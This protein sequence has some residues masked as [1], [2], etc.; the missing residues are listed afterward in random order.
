MKHTRRLIIIPE[1]ELG[2]EA[3]KSATSVDASG[4]SGRAVANV[5]PEA[6][7][8]VEKPER[9]ARFRQYQREQ[10]GDVYLGRTDLSSSGT[11]VAEPVKKFKD[12]ELK[13]SDRRYYEYSTNTANLDSLSAHGDGDI[14]PVL[15][16]TPEDDAKI[17]LLITDSGATGTSRFSFNIAE[18]QRTVYSESSGEFSVKTLP[19]DAQF[20]GS[21]TVFHKA[22]DVLIS[23]DGV[24]RR[25]VSQYDESPSITV[26][27]VSGSDLERRQYYYCRPKLLPL[28]DGRLMS[29]YIQSNMP[30]QH[31]SLSGLEDTAV[32]GQDPVVLDNSVMIQY[33]SDETGK[34]GQA[35]E[36]DPTNTLFYQSSDP[37]TK[38]EPE[39]AA[40][41][42]DAIQFEDTGE[43]V[44]VAGT[45]TVG[46]LQFNLFDNGDYVPTSTSDPQPVGDVNISDLAAG[47]FAQERNLVVLSS[48]DGGQTWK[49]RSLL[50]LRTSGNGIV[51]GALRSD[52]PGLDED[53]I[54][55][56]LGGACEVLDT[57]RIVVTLCTSENIYLLSSDDRGKS[58][59]ASKIKQIS[60][61]PEVV[62]VAGYQATPP[63]EG[64]AIDG[65]IYIPKRYD[66][67]VNGVV[68]GSELDNLDPGYYIVTADEQ[69][70]G[71]QA[72]PI[73][74][75]ANSIF[76]L[77]NPHPGTGTATV[78][79]LRSPSEGATAWASGISVAGSIQE[80]R[81]LIFDT[82]AGAWLEWDARGDW[83]GLLDEVPL[84]YRDSPESN[85]GAVL[86]WVPAS[87]PFGTFDRS[88][89]GSSAGMILKVI[90]GEE[91]SG[92]FLERIYDEQNI[93]TLGQGAF[94]W[95][96]IDGPLLKDRVKARDTLMSAGMTKDSSGAIFCSVSYTDFNSLQSAPEYI[97][98][99]LMKQ[100]LNKDYYVDE[101]NSKLVDDVFTY[102]SDILNP[103]VMHT[104]RR[105]DVF[106]TKDGESST[107]SKCWS[108][109]SAGKA[110][111]EVS[112]PPN[113][114]D[115]YLAAIENSP[116][117]LQDEVFGPACLESSVSIRPDGFPQVYAASHNWMPPEFVG[118]HNDLYLDTNEVP[119]PSPL[120]SEKKVIRNPGVMNV[121]ASQSASQ[122]SS[123][124]DG[125]FFST[126]TVSQ[127]NMSTSQFTV[128]G[129]S[130]DENYEIF[131]NEISLGRMGTEFGERVESLDPRRSSGALPVHGTSSYYVPQ[132]FVHPGA[133]EFY[134][135]SGIKYTTGFMWGLN[136][137]VFMVEDPANQGQGTEGTI[138][139]SPWDDETATLPVGHTVHNVYGDVI[140]GISGNLFF[141]QRFGFDFQAGTKFYNPIVQEI[142]EYNGGDRSNN[143]SYIKTATG[144]LDFVYSYTDNK[145][146][147][148]TGAQWDPVTTNG[149]TKKIKALRNINASLPESGLSKYFV[150]LTGGVTGIDCVQWRG[151]T[152]VLACHT[153]QYNDR[154]YSHSD[155]G[156][157]R[158]RSLKSGG[159]V[160]N[161][162]NSSVV[163][164]KSS[165]WQPIR[166]N[167]GRI[168]NSWDIGM[169]SSWADSLSV[170]GGTPFRDLAV[171]DT[172]EG[173]DYQY[174]YYYGMAGDGLNARNR[175]MRMMT[176]RWYQCTF[177]GQRDP[178]RAGWNV[179]SSSEP[180][181]ATPDSQ[182]YLIDSSMPSNI[183]TSGTGIAPLSDVAAEG[184]GCV[185]WRGGNGGSVVYLGAAENTV[186]NNNTMFLPFSEGRQCSP[187]ADG[188]K[189]T[190]NGS[191]LTGGFRVIFSPFSQESFT[192]NT[193]K[194]FFSLLLNN[195]Q[196]LP[197]TDVDD[198][199]QPPTAKMAGIII[200]LGYDTTL[201]KLTMQAYDGGRLF[202]GPPSN[203]VE[204][205]K[206]VQFDLPAAEGSVDWFEIVA[207]IEESFT[208]TSADGSALVNPYPRPTC[209]HA[210]ARKWSRDDD[211]DWLKSYDVMVN[212]TNIDPHNI[213][214]NSP[215]DGPKGS[216]TSVLFNQ[217]HFVVGNMG[218]GIGGTH[219]NTDE[220]GVVIKSASLHRPGT[221]I[222]GGFDAALNIPSQTGSPLAPNQLGGGIY[223]I[224]V[225]GTD[226][227]IPDMDIVATANDGSGKYLQGDIYTE[228]GPI[229]PRLALVDSSSSD[230]YYG[231]PMFWAG[232]G[233]LQLSENDAGII[234][235][236]KTQQ[237]LSI[238]SWIYRGIKC[239]WRGSAQEAATFAVESN[240]LF[241]AGNMLEGP[242]TKTWKTAKGDTA[243]NVIEQRHQN[244]S[245]PST[246]LMRSAKEKAYVVENM[247]II[248]DSWGEGG[249]AASGDYTNDVY[250]KIGTR[251]Q[252]SPNGIAMFGKN[253]P[254]F[255]ISFYN[256]D[257]DPD[258]VFTRTFG[259]PGDGRVNSI[260]SSWVNNE[261]DRYI[262]LWAW[263]SETWTPQG[264]SSEQQ[265][266]VT[267]G[268]LRYPYF[269]DFTFSYQKRSTT[270][271]HITNLY[272]KDSAA[273]K[274]TPWMPHQFKSDKN[275][276]SYYMQVISEDLAGKSNEACRFIFKIVDNT[277]DTLI[278]D[279]NPLRYLAQYS[280]PVGGTG[281]TVNPPGGEY[282]S[283]KVVSI[284]S[285]RM[286]SEIVYSVI[287]DESKRSGDDGFIFPQTPTL[288]ATGFRYAKITVK[289]CSR[290]GEE[291]SQKLG[292]LIMGRMLDLSGPD[293]EW[294]WSRSEESGVSLRTARGGQRFARKRHSP[295]RKFSVSHHPLR[296]AEEV[297]T[298]DNQD[299]NYFES[300]R[301]GFGSQFG[302]GY[303]QEP[304]T[305]EE[306]V[307]LLRSL[308]P[309]M[310]QA[311]LVWEGD[312]AL[313]SKQPG[314][315]TLSRTGVPCDPT[316]LCLVR[317]TSY[318]QMTHAGFVGVKTRVPVG[319][320]QDA[321]TG[322]DSFGSTACRPRPVIEVTS[323]EFEEEF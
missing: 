43:V 261:P 98:I 150:G 287:T 235:P 202:A 204:I 296:P 139:I 14:V 250:N 185:L 29:L 216:Q 27:Q 103:K 143:A 63:P 276:P 141:R 283:W 127:I 195:K 207:G 35:E 215:Y 62:E 25:D 59:R 198:Q 8:V 2:P 134:S 222:K 254:A 182:I 79:N 318:G 310:E 149:Q 101:D 137:V 231:Q 186:S 155:P 320:Q 92:E 199:D 172:G 34:W 177:D 67:L 69:E 263:T 234:N 209:F 242:V 37:S 80:A 294:G 24:G 179:E 112:S 159:I 291:K 236:S 243:P 138:A 244:W 277:E 184:G 6:S 48:M 144:A 93:S 200:S 73:I 251:K 157:S 228:W 158:N 104:E 114:G 313:E 181:A 135:H 145:I 176:G 321:T 30:V 309:G 170:V 213:P 39:T 12:D 322:L 16:G 77:I 102:R 5:E 54:G 118:P 208:Q 64:E 293:F 292:R 61:S 194:V 224:R 302:P 119:G 217:E 82:Q 32:A 68:R 259:L 26:P 19:G 232:A 268:E 229:D 49:R 211:P 124:D 289:G 126:D 317:L 275:G 83:D 212:Y 180:D 42:A 46:Q 189:K 323:I 1:A 238:P 91:Y 245:S 154:Y 113:S 306:V 210:F 107:V 305:W 192:P 247:E 269:G 266:I 288:P 100:T 129:D 17:N 9:G 233:A 161:N 74:D 314:S 284:F 146:L 312:S 248:L 262:H 171:N 76:K 23:S 52:V 45:N 85:T 156:S 175:L 252:F 300:P 167:L 319:S 36:L 258:D 60:V 152:V 72:N 239:L 40:F 249:D 174:Y 308:G 219:T 151:Q 191:A 22:P 28:K 169:G 106:T 316:D 241:S 183:T 136:P 267:G 274:L 75:S 3:V 307:H 53:D 70:S 218:A 273:D 7:P 315:D 125:G 47:A 286:A 304:R 214:A 265:P 87:D 205:G 272:T 97:S 255:E 142:W 221:Q 88:R 290:V 99:S 279:E 140:S 116:A 15:S 187:V 133:V 163:S 299:S 110:S 264:Y 303:K 38:G 117:A 10:D 18:E 220:G 86:K 11:P 225:F 115:Q 84:V 56:I 173:Q 203:V 227:T 188:L 298:G 285:D 270:N 94:M 311:A 164:Y 206:P 162:D 178:A 120:F 201:R 81:S 295:R 278:L 196:W 57:G 197:A 121:V 66:Y 237:C 105:T 282:R 128:T 166:E 226:Q 281:G 95:E 89:N 253:F 122:P 55:L 168:D 257:S 50:N 111:V 165:A 33:A 160:S 130:K 230:F 51:G 21:P 147:E 153:H 190:S 44:L 240:H 271:K 96:V 193:F 280:Y 4:S 297:F 65:Q 58:F 108:Y 123:N 256:D 301:R 260:T 132:G 71:G 223:D 31:W 148:W 41:F 131:E 246:G 90:G 20:R 13:V 109:S 78:E